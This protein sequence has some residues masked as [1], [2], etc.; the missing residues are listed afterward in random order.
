M[1]RRGDVEALRYTARLAIPQRRL[2]NL[3]R[4]MFRWR[5]P[6]RK[7]GV[8]TSD[9]LAHRVELRFVSGAS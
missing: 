9:L 6:G 3:L 4:K 8:S 1:F 7:A 2:R 5:M